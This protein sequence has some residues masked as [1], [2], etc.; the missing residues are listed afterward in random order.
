MAF[1][2]ILGELICLSVSAGYA[3]VVTST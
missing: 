2:G 3:I 1:R